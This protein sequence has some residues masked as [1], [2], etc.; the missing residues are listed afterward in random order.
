MRLYS[1]FRSSASYRV[2]IA[3]HLKG[4]AFS[5]VPV[6]MLRGGGEQ[7]RPEYSDINA[8]RLVPTL[9]ID[10]RLLSQSMAICE[11]LEERWPAP[12]LLPKNAESRARVRAIAS[13]IACEI[14]PLNN[15]RVLDYL[16]KQLG[17]TVEQK[18]AWYRHWISLGLEGVERMLADSPDTGVY[19][20]GD[21]PTLADAFLVPQVANALRYQCP[22]DVYPHIMRINEH[23]LR[24]PAFIAA[25]PGQQPDR[26]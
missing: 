7:H 2:R 21:S 24:H 11:F 20:H 23:C 9:E 4:L 18:T 17:T 19:C 22:V 26:E 15:L 12:P 3:L 16:V 14:H 6:H 8:L 25:S 10:G 13:A 1:Y 5:T